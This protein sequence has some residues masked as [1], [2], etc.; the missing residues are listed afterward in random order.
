MADKYTIHVNPQVS[1]SDAQ[2]MENE[3]NQRF[4][5]VSK[6]FG[7]NLKN[8]LATSLKIG[9]AAGL[10]GMVGLVATNPFEKVN[11]DLKSTLDRADEIA[12][13]AQQFGVSTAEMFK[14]TSLAKSV[15]LDVDLALQ[16]FAN[17][18]QEARDFKAG[19][20]SKSP[21]LANY[22]GKDIATS[23][24]D[25][26]RTA[27]NLPAVER[28][29]FIGKIYGDKMQL[30]IAELAQQN[31]VKRLKDIENSFG[32]KKT[33]KAINILAEREDYQKILEQRRAGEEFVRKSKV[34]TKG[35]IQAEDA[36]ARA[37]LNREV[38]NLSQFEI[39]ARQAAL[40]EEMLKSIDELRSHLIEVAFPVL[41]KAVE[42]LGFVYDKIVIV[43]DWLGK[44]VVAI[45]KL[46]F[47]G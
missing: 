20:A 41:Q 7:T 25:F 42:I 6:K 34:I 13:R 32:F 5:S 1:S 23:F 3:L 9:A 12:T 14:L 33:G 4:A 2:K 19:D 10:A 44:I 31:I 36:V 38:Q 35:T 40:Q 24:I 22:I 29:A 11:E 16:N 8:T 30:K 47:W 39:Y 27:S 21:L 18:L 37:K 26:I 43:I 28:N 15:G 46:K 45:K 17:K